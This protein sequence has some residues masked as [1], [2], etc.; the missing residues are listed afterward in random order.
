VV[1][2]TNLLTANAGAPWVVRDLRSPVIKL[3]YYPCAA[4][5]DGA[6]MRA[7]TA[8]AQRVHAALRLL[9]RDVRG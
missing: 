2:K 8:P 7:A 6:E 3:H 9:H 1:S 4:D 5:P